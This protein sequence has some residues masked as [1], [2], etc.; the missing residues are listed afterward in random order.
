MTDAATAAWRADKSTSAAMPWDAF[1]TAAELEPDEDLYCVATWGIMGLTAAPAFVKNTP[2][3]APLKVLPR[4]KCVGVS[5]AVRMAW[6]FKFVAETLTVW[7]G[8]EHSAEFFRSDAHRRGMD[9]LR[10]QVEFRARRVWIRAADLP[11]PGGSPKA[12][13]DAVKRGEHRAVE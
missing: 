10:G 2:G 6:P 4:G 11:P 12:L 1:A 8:R 9:A 13:W 3:S 7:H 5:M